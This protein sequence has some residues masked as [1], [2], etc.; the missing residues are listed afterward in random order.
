MD[1]DAVLEDTSL[2]VVERM[3]SMYVFWHNS[4]MPLNRF[5]HPGELLLYLLNVVPEFFL[6]VLDSVDSSSN[7][8][9]IFYSRIKSGKEYFT[10]Y[11]E[12]RMTCAGMS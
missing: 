4:N 6:N 11:Y 5:G 2:I 8:S 10:M 12:M 7:E 1:E 9:P 3:G